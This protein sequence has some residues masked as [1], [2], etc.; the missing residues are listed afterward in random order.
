MQID[1][2]DFV[3]KKIIMKDF[4]EKAK[5]QL[6]E[7]LPFVIYKKPNNNSVVGYFQ[8]CNTV[9]EAH[10]YSEKGFVF[11]T[12]DGT[13]S[14]LIPEKNSVRITSIFLFDSIENTI[15]SSVITD[16]KSDK[17]NFETLVNLGIDS[18][19]KGQFSKVVLSRKEAIKVTDFDAIAT[20]VRVAQNYPTAFCY[21][22]FHPKIGLWI[23][24][25]PEQLL[26]IDGTVLTTVSL[27]GT[28]KFIENE[29]VVWGDK[30]KNEQQ[31]VTNSIIE[32]LKN[33]VDEIIVSNPYTAKAGNLVHIKTDIKGNLKPG[34][35]L[36]NLL[37]KLH[38]TPAVCGFPR[39]EAQNFI[40]NNEGYDR[41]FYSGFF[42]E[43]NLDENT[44]TLLHV[45]LRCME[46]ENNNAH[47][48]I[49][50]GITQNSI[51]ELEWI[52]TVNKA[53]TMK[54]IVI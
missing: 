28:Q 17:N 29:T 6:L 18:I 11:S 2:Y 44:P 19:K 37:S 48:Y 39:K 53:Q 36:S 49:G 12:F 54:K 43:I 8:N 30:E 38:P 50:C 3:I 35:D 27:A 22:W 15:E 4:L 31:I 5:Q 10:N 24:A 47:L 40:K 41:R 7:N 51:P 34:F 20:F 14:I 26:K 52:E 16:N 42:G 33:E 46:I 13:K 21:C 1:K 9:F 25:S 45:I 23:G 32:N